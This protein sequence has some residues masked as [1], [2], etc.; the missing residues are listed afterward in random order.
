MQNTLKNVAR[1]SAVALALSVAAGCA[2]VSTQDFEQLRQEAT[3]AR[4]AADQAN[5]AANEAKTLASQ[6]N[7]KGDRALR[8]ADD[9]NRCC[10]ETKES[11]DRMFKQ[12]MQK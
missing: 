8:A 5:R 2:T 10:Q 4:A 1:V 11:I 3:E 6:A 12:T 7:D 9:A